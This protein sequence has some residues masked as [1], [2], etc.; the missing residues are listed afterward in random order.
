MSKVWTAFSVVIVMMTIF[1]WAIDFVTLQG[2]RTIYTA[3]CQGAEWRG[4]E[5]PGSVVAAERYRFR[6]LKAKDEVVFWVAGS[7]EP[8][9]KLTPCMIHD[10]RNWTCK[11]TVDASKSITLE[12]REGVAIA[13]PAGSTRPF[14][15][16]SKWR[17]YRLRYS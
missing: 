17:W 7:A 2:E 13:D 12:M 9:G 1:I 15:A 14:H 8:S 3:T 4:D 16:V 10:G 6:A 5:C 11:A